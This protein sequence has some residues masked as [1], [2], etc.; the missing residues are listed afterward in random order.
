MEL[1]KEDVLKCLKSKNEEKVIEGLNR[2]VAAHGPEAC[3]AIFQLLAS[4][5]L[6]QQEAEECWQQI[7]A[8]WEKM[9]SIMG[10]QI[11]L[12]TVV[13][14]Y[15][16]SI[17]KS[18]KNPKVVEIHIFEKT[19][20]NSNYDSLTELFNRQYFDEALI[21]ELAL[22]KRYST[23][24]A[25]LF[26]DID[27]FKE[28]NDTYGHQAGDKALQHIARI[29]KDE[30][31]IGDI[32]TRYGGEELALILPQTGSISAVVVAERIRKRIE[33]SRLTYDKQKIKMTVSGGLSSFPTD[34]QAADELLKI[35]DSA[36]YRAKGLG[37]NNVSFFSQDKRRYVRIDFN[38]KVDIRELGFND[39][40]PQTA[41]SKNISIGGILFENSSPLEL[42]TQVQVNIP[43]NHGD[44]LLIIGKVVR[45]EELGPE[46][47][48]I[49]L[50]ITFREMDK[51]AKN[52]ISRY[53][54]KFLKKKAATPDLP[55]PMP[56][57][58]LA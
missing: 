27:D 6:D 19:I 33:K 28:V 41:A 7:I 14:D 4:L 38:K 50:C 42:G 25:I 43:I 53:V 48:D 20:K 52:E 31:R 18:L 54:T 12:R 16:C 49:G 17:H 51:T 30:K 47:F 34:A 3:Q 11:S 10:R 23:E 40:A 24:L 2:L 8:H 13:C 9:C 56:G 46:K 36:L 55:L 29:I 21:R 39:N 5:D 15:F 1:L 32:A 58:A 45:V 22:A 37:K 26:F 35:A 57:A 44:P